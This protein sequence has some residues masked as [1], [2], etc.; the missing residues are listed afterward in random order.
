MHIDGEYVT[1]PHL[2][3]FACHFRK[4]LQNIK[5]LFS[6][7][8][9]EKIKAGL[10]NNSA[11]MFSSKHVHKTRNDGGADTEVILATTHWP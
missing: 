3:S 11:S 4:C 8:N 2:F 9:H 6:K 1:K 7:N 10:E 5:M